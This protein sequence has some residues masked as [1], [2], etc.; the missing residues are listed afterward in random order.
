MKFSTLLLVGIASAMPGYNPGQQ[1]DNRGM[2]NEEGGYEYFNMEEPSGIQGNEKG[3]YEDFSEDH[4]SSMR[5][6]R[7]PSDGS[8]RLNRRISQKINGNQGNQGGS[9]D[10]H[11]LAQV[12]AVRAKVGTPPLKL[13]SKLKIAAQKHSEY[14]AETSKMSHFG[15]GGSSPTQRINA[16]GIKGA[17]QAWVYSPSHYRNLVDKGFKYV[18]FG[19]NNK[20]YTQDFSS[21]D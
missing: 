16:A 11:I 5:L 19:E 14:Q 1:R 10:Q 7:G 21:N 2:S 15:S 3:G 17:I 12:N 8:R 20:Y 6:N 9:G 18:A 13:S 4:P